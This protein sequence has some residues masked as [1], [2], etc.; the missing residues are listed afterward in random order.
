MTTLHLMVGLPC[1]GKTTLSKSL[2][3]ELGAL[4]L[5]PDEWHRLLFG[6]DAS[7]PEH[8]ARHDKIELLQWRVAATALARGL[9]VILDF[10]LWSKT[11][12]DEFRQRAAALGADT[13]IHF[14]DVSFKELLE[15][16]DQRNKHA[17]EEVT[18]IPPAMMDEY[19]SRFQA[20]DAQELSLN[21]D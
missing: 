4:R 10:G 21:A 14:L 1:S 13:K 18:F 11:E 6:Q 15:R 3:I 5:T 16:L 8:D 20:P 9:D 19:L 17:A 7:H 12:R 2:E